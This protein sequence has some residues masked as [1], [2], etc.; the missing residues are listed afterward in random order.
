MKNI[1]EKMIFYDKSY[2]VP[3]KTFEDNIESNENLIS[4]INSKEI[5]CNINCFEESNIKQNSI[6]VNNC[7]LSHS[8]GRLHKTQISY[9]GLEKPILKTSVNANKSV[10]YI[11]N[12]FIS[13]NDTNSFNEIEEL[14]ENTTEVF[15]VSDEFNKNDISNQSFSI[16]DKVKIISSNKIQQLIN[17]MQKD[18]VEIE[19][20]NIPHFF[21]DNKKYIATGELNNNIFKWYLNCDFIEPTEVNIDYNNDT[22]KLINKFNSTKNICLTYSKSEIFVESNKLM[23]KLLPISLDGTAIKK[24]KIDLNQNFINPIQCKYNFNNSYITGNDYYMNGN[25]LIHPKSS[26]S[27]IGKITLQNK[28]YIRSISYDGKYS[29]PT[30]SS[31]LFFCNSL[32]CLNDKKEYYGKILPFKS[33]SFEYRLNNIK[34]SNNSK[35]CLE[36]IW[37]I[38]GIGEWRNIILTIDNDNMTNYG[39]ELEINS[40]ISYRYD[41]YTGWNG[42]N[43]EGIYNEFVN[44]VFGEI[45]SGEID[46]EWGISESDGIIEYSVD[47]GD[48][49]NLNSRGLVG[50]I[51][52]W[53]S[54]GKI[55]ELIVWKNNNKEIVYDKI[56][57]I[58]LNCEEFGGIC[59]EKDK[60]L[61]IR[62]DNNEWIDIINGDEISGSAVDKIEYN[63]EGNKLIFI[64]DLSECV[65]LETNDIENQGIHY[66]RIFTFTGDGLFNETFYRILGVNDKNVDLISSNPVF[67]WE[68]TEYKYAVDFRKVEL[69]DNGY[70]CGKNELSIDMNRVGISEYEIIFDSNG[71]EIK[72]IGFVEYRE[73]Y[74][75]KEIEIKEGAV[76]GVCSYNKLGEEIVFPYEIKGNKLIF[77]GEDELFFD[78]IRVVVFYM[79]NKWSETHIRAG[80][81]KYDIEVNKND[82]VE[83]NTVYKPLKAYLYNSLN[84]EVQFPI[85]INENNIKIDLSDSDKLMYNDLKK[86]VI[87]VD[88]GVDGNGIICEKFEILQKERRTYFNPVIS[89]Y[90]GKYLPNKIENG[91]VTTEFPFYVEKSKQYVICDMNHFCNENILSKVW[92]NSD[93]KFNSYKNNF[94]TFIS[95]SNELKF[96]TEWKEFNEEFD[97]CELGKYFKLKIQVFVIEESKEKIL[98]YNFAFENV[99]LAKRNE[100]NNKIYFSMSEELENDTLYM[101]RV[102]SYNGVKYSDWSELECFMTSSEKLNDGASELY[103]DGNDKRV[104]NEIQFNWNGNQN[105]LLYDNTTTLNNK[106]GNANNFIEGKEYTWQVKD[107]ESKNSNNK[108]SVNIKPPVPTFED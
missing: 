72:N 48:S 43:Y 84:E 37:N 95:C 64:K 108:F 66:G 58:E 76:I 81:E 82:L 93:R 62:V 13:S 65:E 74:G 63:Y 59:F 103:I 61:K 67:S 97:L 28:S 106:T 25:I 60:M 31:E 101:M 24:I 88:G 80:L 12:D 100:N 46:H 42:S 73:Y 11:F 52:Q 40:V 39:N 77:I 55:S 18:Y 22:N 14:S 27:S 47:G 75:N 56:G 29:L 36:Y 50:Q 57:E 3:A 90:E 15:F 92:I 53:R 69:K 49:W 30:Y 21:I 16:S 17:L 9:I 99:K 5:L 2:L 96:W 105:I 51:L 41:G 87:L 89:I 83:L 44:N 104:F 71:N 98:D 35:E 23:V 6:T 33:E 38:R 54:V 26:S 7:I 68:G 45:D 8:E 107:N 86:A 32:S 94:K 79:V 1:N 85:T 34:F 91:V 70:E 4:S 20:D 10:P 19:S 78:E 102:K